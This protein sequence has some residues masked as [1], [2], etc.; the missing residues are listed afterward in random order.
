MDEQ[1]MSKKELLELTGISYG[2]LY[3]WKRKGLIPEDWFIKKSSYT[4]QE[5]FF[6]RDRVLARIERIKHMKDDIALDDLV[7]LFTPSL[8]KITLTEAELRQRNLVSAEA[9]LLYQTDRP[10]PDL[11]D[12]RTILQIAALDQVIAQ[13]AL[14]REDTH[15]LLDVLS[16][17]LARFPEAPCDVWVFNKCDIAFTVLIS[18]P[19]QICHDPSAR[20]LARI[21]LDHVGEGLKAKLLEV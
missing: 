2:Q 17:G 18:P 6:P 13:C 7:D 14:S 1:L 21:S 10:L 11:I 20:L 19:G 12:Y 15:Q 16:D 5:T 4:G 8:Q 3:R 9:L